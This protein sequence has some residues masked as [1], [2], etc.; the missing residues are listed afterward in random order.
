MDY[1]WN[2]TVGGGEDLSALRETCPGAASSTANPTRE[3]LQ[4]EGRSLRRDFMDVHRE[5]WEAS[6]YQV[7][8]SVE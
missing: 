2:D 6:C 7:N 5:E 4:I 3:Y 1:W 8:C